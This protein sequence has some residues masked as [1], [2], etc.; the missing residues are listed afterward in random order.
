M[1]ERPEDRT[2]TTKVFDLGDNDKL[3]R[4][5]AGHQHYKDGSGNFQQIDTTIRTR[6]GGWEQCLDGDAARIEQI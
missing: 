3:V 2:Y 1:I 4:C 6:V 5:F